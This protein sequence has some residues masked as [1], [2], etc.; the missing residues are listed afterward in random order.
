M[1]KYH[2]FI[3]YKSKTQTYSEDEPKW[4]TQCL[5]DYKTNEKNNEKVKKNENSFSKFFSNLLPRR[6]RESKPPKK[7]LRKER[8]LGKAALDLICN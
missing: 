3:T 8:Q 7:P 6:E 1:N 2:N 5:N 4:V